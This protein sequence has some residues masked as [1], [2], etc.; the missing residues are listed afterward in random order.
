M[1]DPRTFT[2][3]G[4]FKDGI[5]P[6]L[7][8]INNQLAALKNSFS[9]IGGKGAR[10]ASRDLGKFNAAVEGLSNTL[11]IQN[12]VLKSTI[13]PMRQYRREVGKTIGALKRLDEAGG[14]SI[15][16]ER[17]N[18]A[19]Q[20]QI[21]LMD[22]LRSRRGMA[23]ARMPR[24][25]G[26]G[27]G[28]GGRGPRP[29][30][31]GGRGGMDNFHM[32]EFA[33]AFQLGNALSQP[34][35][36][37]VVAGFQ[38]GVGMMTKPFQYFADNLK[39]RIQD[40]QSDIKAA[41]GIFSISK[42][43]KDPLVRTMDEA[44]EFTQ[45][46]NKRMEE[47]AAALPGATEDYIEVGKRIS[48]S[49]ARIVTRDEKASVQYANQLRAERGAEM[50]TET[51]RAGTK[52][53]YTELLGKMTTQT[54]LAGLGTGGGGP[55]GLVGAYGL[56][57][58]TERML[59]QDQVSMG[60]FQRYAAIFRDPLIMESLSR[61]IPK[62][63]ATTG[64]TLERFKILD[65]LFTEVLP[66]EMIRKYEKSAAGIMEAFRTTI[67]GKEGGLFGLGRKMK[68]L[69]KTMDDFG[70]YIKV[71]DD[72]TRVVVKTM[73]EATDAELDLF[74]LFSDT[75]GNLAIVLF[76]IVQNLSKL[77]DPLRKIG[78]L[79]T[80]ARHLTGR[81]LFSFESYKAGLLEMVKVMPDFQ[82]KEFLKIG[83]DLR[84]SLAAVNN[85]FRGLG[86]ISK[87]DFATNAQKIMSD[88]FDVGKMIQ[89]MIDQ[90]MKS[91]L[92][93]SIGETIGKIIGTVLV[94]VS[95]VTGFISGR[96]EKSNKLL[97][98]L[99]KGLN[100]SG[101]VEAF[102]SIFRDVFKAI[103]NAIAFII[104]KLP[105]QVLATAGIALIAPA[106][107]ST[108][109]L[110][111]SSWLGNVI[112][113]LLTG[114]TAAQCISKVGASAFCGPQITG[115]PSGKRKGRQARNLGAAFIPGTPRERI[116][117][118]RSMQSKGAA[119]SKS[120]KMKAL[121]PLAAGIVTLSTK[122]PAMAKA[123]KAITN[124]G[125][126]IPV[127][128]TVFSVLD[129]GL[130]KMAGESTA[131]AAGGAIGAGAGGILGGIL[132]SALG[133]GG[134]I[135]GG[136]LGTVIGD[137][138]GTEIGKVAEKIPQ[139]LSGLP[140]QLSSAWQGL[141]T[142][143]R[144]LPYSLGVAVGRTK[145]LMEQGWNTFTSWMSNLGTQFGTWLQKTIVSV[146]LKWSNFIAQLVADFQTGKAWSKLGGALKSG[147]QKMI[148]EIIPFILNMLNPVSW[149]SKGF[150]LA[151]G[152]F[153]DFGKGYRAG[154][155]QQQSATPLSPG[156][157][158]SLSTF[159]N[160]FATSPPPAKP[161]YQG[162]LGDAISKEMQMKP[163]GSDLVIANSSETVIP[164]AGGYGMLDFVETLRAGFNR[165]ATVFQTAQQKQDGL[166]RQINN[167]LV[168]NQQQTNARLATLETKFTSPTM[169]GGLGGAS[170]GGVDAFTSV[171]QSF[172]LQM[173]SG[174]RPGD[175]GWH[176]A[177]RARDF[178]N[179]TG[180]TPQMMQFAQYLASTYGS[181]LKE[182]IY[183][184]LG[185][186]VKDGQV[187]PPYAQNSHYNH[188][189]VAYALGPNNGKMFSNLSAARSWE[190]SMVP[191][192]VKVASIT[193]NSGEGFGGETSVIN[194]FTITQRDGED[195]EALANR[196]ATLF[197]DAM[198]NAQSASIFG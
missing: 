115:G 152:A 186:S 58:L 14:R 195:G 147:F 109:A 114:K 119:F 135:A 44:M 29:P 107:I 19:L 78:T 145:V 161:K 176:G 113:G 53:A 169:P 3:I 86:V 156:T 32:A 7:Q 75:V 168:T 106:L 127:L 87:S 150:D 172:G 99:E 42:R 85:L 151:K 118:M 50:I 13:E 129:F 60:Q 71:L 40:Q 125:K 103:F 26:M 167:T 65:K 89:G 51:G 74:N 8:K 184:P 153:A 110:G 104:P 194:N 79:L 155:V 174:Y 133:P 198:N 128:S 54:V 20:E 175:P 121:G 92:A 122:A 130:R 39:E 73:A 52:K 24:E 43:M 45:Q 66:P 6:E 57:G 37:A 36:N 165:M 70:N 77:W 108:F 62:I 56:P 149:I 46:N 131:V 15:A 48:D 197:Y 68:G 123:G 88:S 160:M 158:P 22:Q 100:E 139:L 35:T 177:N 55:G 137:W 25:P 134:T 84:A 11:K 117:R 31:A 82:K 93:N 142:W 148:T 90:F 140:A 94:E 187:V 17:T 41:G 124:I 193:G 27:G 49:V 181:S 102:G 97:T 126:R 146:K 144:N 141:E 69:G 164:A 180:P 138:L 96:I 81:L 23:P 143:F 163:P 179:G 196:V 101:G 91:D 4:E 9:N 5:T 76:P 183:T 159:D 112:K 162:S 21:R 38:I 178:S 185:Y 173:T 63:N 166:L 47:L 59:T 120:L 30:R 188:V 136:I 18:K 80:D 2:L 34:I 33:F 191:G 132:G 105:W 61:F 111:L 189:H 192:S 182:L 170:A 16:I 72:G 157:P 116:T 64:G 83:V 10:T 154:V 190:E 95:K 98:G 12:S 28:G 1:A 171:A 67:F